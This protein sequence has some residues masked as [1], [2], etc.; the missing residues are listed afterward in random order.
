MAKP[1]IRVDTLRN[2]TPDIQ[3]ANRGTERG[4]G[5]L[6]HSLRTHGAGRS[7]LVDKH[8][9]IIAGNKTVETAV[10]IGLE[11]AL[12]VETDGTQVVVVKRTDLDLEHDP[13]AKALAVADNRVAELG[14]AW[15]ADVLKALVA[16]QTDMTQLF[17]QNELAAL[18][19][20]SPDFEP[21]VNPVSVTDKDVSAQQ[22]GMESR[23]QGKQGYVD[24]ICPHCAKMFSVAKSDVEA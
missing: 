1:S 17:T 20:Y 5:A 13:E 6:E 7:I 24:V 12:V 8:G 4:R 23:F 15:D 10:D 21:T 2:L 11:Q 14:L 3:N 22:S 16:E 19:P 18:V 9:R